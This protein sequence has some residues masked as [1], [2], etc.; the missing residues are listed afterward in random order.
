MGSRSSLGLP[1]G[2]AMSIKLDHLL[3]IERKLFVSAEREPFDP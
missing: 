3:R 2:S 1:T